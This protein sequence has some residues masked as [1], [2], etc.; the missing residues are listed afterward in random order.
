MDRKERRTHP[1]KRAHIAANMYVADGKI[2]ATGQVG[3]ISLGGVFIQMADPLPVNTHM[4]IKFVLPVEPIVHCKGVVIW[5]S[6][7]VGHRDIP[8]ENIGIG[9]QLYELARA[10]FELIAELL[11]EEPDE[12]R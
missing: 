1:R 10:D 9:V 5:T 3:N 7:I 2:A 4:E 8:S 6:E 12:T 11:A